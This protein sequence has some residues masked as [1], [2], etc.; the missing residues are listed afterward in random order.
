MRALRTNVLCI[1]VLAVLPAVCLHSPAQAALLMEEPYGFFGA[2]NPTGHDAMYFARICA[3]TPIKLRRCA[4]GE[5]GIAITRYQG[6]AG[7]DWVA[8]PL[9]PY[10]YSVENPSDVPARV[11]RQAVIALR[12]RYHEAHLRSLG[13]DVPEGSTFRRGW[14]QLVGVAYERRIYA[15]R[16]ATTEEQDDALIVRMNAG[17]NHSRYSLIF[18][19]CA[20]F[21]SDILNHYFPRTFR[22]RILPDAGITTPMQVTHELVRYARKHPEMQLQV[23][24]IPQIPG[25]RGPSRTNKSIAKSLLT[26]GYVVP[27]AFL[28]PPA[29]GGLVA[30]YL[31]W[32]RYPLPLKQAQVLAP[33]DVTQLANSAGAAIP[34]QLQSRIAPPR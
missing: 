30:D 8:M 26:S 9:I 32:G 12:E 23:F 31:V 14:N 18:W 33:A 11:D 3:E 1:A 29:A 4:P 28:C 6:I 5:P 34:V 15:F 17:A 27:L 25:Y 7:Y 24:Q 10:F 13:K 21:S 22:R 2:L 19:N 20:D 16:F